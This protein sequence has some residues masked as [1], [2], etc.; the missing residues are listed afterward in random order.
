MATQSAEQGLPGFNVAQNARFKTATKLNRVQQQLIIEFSRKILEVHNQNTEIFNKMEVIDQAYARYKAKKQEGADGVDGAVV[1]DV[2]DKDRVTPPIVVSQ[3]DSAVAYLSE[4][5]LSG[6]PLFPVVSTPKNKKWAEQ[7]EVL[8]DDHARLGGYARQM[9]IFL[10]DAVKYNYSALHCSWE[11]MEQFEV[12]SDFTNERNA[13]GRKVKK[14][15]SFLNE[16]ER[17]DP[18]NVVRDPDV[19]PGDISK[20]GDYAGW[21]KSYSYIK[22]KRMLEKMAATDFGYNKD[23]ILSTNYQQGPVGDTGAVAWRTPP[24]ISDYVTAKREGGTNWDAY[25]RGG[26]KNAARTSVGNGYNFFTFY[27]RIV[28]TDFGMSVPQKG[29]PQIWKFTVVNNTHLAYAER[30][31]S[32]YDCIPIF[33]GQPLED[34]LGYQTQSIA[35]GEIPF[36]EAA[37]TL[38]NIRFSAARRAVADRALFIADMIKPSDVNSKNPAAKIP[39]NISAMSTKTL[40][41]AYKQIPFDMRGTET[42]ISDAREIV[43]FSQQL[44]GLNGPRQGQFQKGN[45]SVTE[46]QDT[47]GSSDG[48]SRLPALTLEYQVF[49]PMREFMLLNIFQYGENVAVVSQRTGEQIDINVDELRKQVLAFRLADGFTP[50][51]K[52]ASTEAIQGGLQLIS[53]SPI[54]QQV[55]GQMLPA[56]FAHLMALQGVRGLEEYNPVQPS[57][58][59]GT[60]PGQTGVIPPN[61]AIPMVPGMPDPASGPNGVTQ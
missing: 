48:R 32:A 27:A 49:V 13:Q 50:K 16:V 51:S 39:V 40:D 36:Q 41:Q 5:F 4:V 15:K 44:H 59:E 37:S 42:T 22:C 34:G 2:F 60:M 8:M 35:E 17:L 57:A 61:P 46:W 53:T 43:Q 21:I 1:C 6:S 45:K 7:L 10:R 14:N 11:V 20:K 52:L 47:M 18:Y 30:I 56:M 23:V 33:F 55:Y 19:A 24:Q 26:D 25:I 54:L 3:V 12:L 58:Q 29:T 9:L 28:P 38:F 31:V